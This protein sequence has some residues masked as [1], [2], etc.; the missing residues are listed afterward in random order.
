MS[1]GLLQIVKGSVFIYL[2][3]VSVDNGP[4]CFVPG[5]H[6]NRG[7]HLL[8]DG[9]FSDEEIKLYYGSDAIKTITG[10]AG[11]I[12]IAN[13][14]ALHR[15]SVVNQGKRR[16]LQLIYSNSL[17]GAHQSQYKMNLLDEAHSAKL[18]PIIY[19]NPR[20]FQNFRLC[21]EIS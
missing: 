1:E 20:L 19:G 11:T 12:F 5:S 14:H 2:D 10:E 21:S 4:H 15:G 16:I 18:E 8:R 7:N 17:F 3:D 6:R 13:T 9:R